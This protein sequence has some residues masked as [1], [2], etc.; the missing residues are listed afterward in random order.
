MKLRVYI[1]TSVVGGYFDDEFE[2]VTK[3]FFE[4]IFKKD[5]LVYFSEVSEA[6]ISLA[7]DFVKNLK[8][9]I[10]ADCYRFLDLDNES[11]ELAETYIN[12]KILGKASLDD[13][14]HI[15]IATVNRLDVLVSWNFKH[16]VNYDKI[17]L[18]N[19]INLRLGYPMIEIRSPKEF[20]SYENN[21]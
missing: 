14:Y 17:K 19:S 21:D 10:P 3:L 2:D 15:A 6:E 18:F 13:A 8:S 7:P 9:K 12:E 11:K 20:V 4:R 1:D 16:I 5:F